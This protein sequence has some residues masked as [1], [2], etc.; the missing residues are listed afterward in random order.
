[1]RTLSSLHGR[2]CW[3]PSGSFPRIFPK[4]SA[5]TSILTGACNIQVERL[6]TS[7]RNV[8]CAARMSALLT[9]SLSAGSRLL[10]PPAFPPEARGHVSEK[11]ESTSLSADWGG[12]AWPSPSTWRERFGRDWYWWDARHFRRHRNGKGRS[13][14]R[15][16]R[17]ARFRKWRS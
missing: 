1:E 4:C 3:G 11:K 17:A 9:G 13:A 6:E 7:L 16:L 10:R 8:L 5:A 2:R 14:T 12:L 15:A